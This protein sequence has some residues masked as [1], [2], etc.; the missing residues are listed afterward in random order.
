MKREVVLAGF[1]VVLL[2]SAGLLEARG[3]G[4]PAGKQFAHFGTR[5]F[6]HFGHHGFRGFAFGMHA[7]PGFSY[8]YCTHRFYNSCYPFGYYPPPFYGSSFY[9]S[10]FP[11][12]YTVYGDSN[13]SAPDSGT[14]AAPDY[15]GDSGSQAYSGRISAAAVCKDSWREKQNSSSLSSVIN[16][17]FELQCENGHAMSHTNPLEGNGQD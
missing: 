15:D 11:F 12:E 1:L 8:G 2:A 17:V 4:H 10:G 6:G 7:Y 3:S 16:S 13:Y 9:T 14:L 5:G